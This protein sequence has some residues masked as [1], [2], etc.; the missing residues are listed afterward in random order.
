MSI[1]EYSSHNFNDTYEKLTDN[2]KEVLLV[3]YYI[4]LSLTLIQVRDVHDIFENDISFWRLKFII[5][6]LLR[7]GLIKYFPFDHTYILMSRRIEI[8]KYQA[9]I[10]ETEQN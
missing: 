8:S 6:S 5:F 9:V 10:W 3:I 7:K 4:S 2:E 1:S